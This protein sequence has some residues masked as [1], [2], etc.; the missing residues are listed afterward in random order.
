M[1][2]IVDYTLLRVESSSGLPELNLMVLDYINKG[3]S[4]L[5]GIS[6]NSNG[7]YIQTMVKY[8]KE[9]D[10]PTP[11]IVAPEFPKINRG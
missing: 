1:N 4:P 8:E 5:G 7:V 2:K 6:F 10:Y 9:Q 11:G 3:W